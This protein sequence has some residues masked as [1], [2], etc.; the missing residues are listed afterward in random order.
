MKNS[1][2]KLEFYKRPIDKVVSHVL[3]M[4]NIWKKP[5]CNLEKLLSIESK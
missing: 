2:P 5:A 4:Q 3:S 1:Q